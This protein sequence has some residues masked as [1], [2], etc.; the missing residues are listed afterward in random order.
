MGENLE[1]ETFKYKYRRRVMQV[2]T[3]II[4]SVF[5]TLKVSLLV[6]MFSFMFACIFLALGHDF[7]AP[8]L[9]KRKLRKNSTI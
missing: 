3:L 4:L 1:F 7:L 5:I 6:A 8:F 9:A 2:F